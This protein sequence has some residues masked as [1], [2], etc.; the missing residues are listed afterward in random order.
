M[1]A[2]I[3]AAGKSTRTYPLTVTRPKPLLKLLD[4]TLIEHNLDQLKGIVDE[5][6]IV[7]GF[8][9]DQIISK[10][11]NLYSGIKISYIEQ[12]EQL[13]T[14]HALQI[15]KEA[16]KEEEQILVMVGDD[17]YSAEDIKKCVE[18]KNCMLACVVPNP[19]D[20]GVLEVENG[21]LIKI[22]E[23]QKDPISELVNTGLYV[24]SSEIFDK[25]ETIKKSERGE[26]ELTDAVSMLKIDV[27]DV[28]GYWIPV[29]YPWNLLEANVFMLKKCELE[30][31]GT[32]E[33]NVTIKGKVHIGKG[34]IIK[35]GSYIEGPV[36]IGED[37]EIGPMAHIRPDTI[38][39]NNVRMGKTELYDVLI[40]DGATSKHMGYCAH[41]IVG[42]NVNFG[43]GTITADYRHDGKNNFTKIK[44]QKI[45]TR[46]RKLGAFIGDNVNTGIGTL[47]YPGRKL[48]PGTTTLPGEIV[49]EDKV[50]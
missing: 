23:K 38:I 49:K 33:E 8:E 24:I 37:C 42:E 9:K 41:S 30:N 45:D 48:W 44:G 20:Y 46:R 12:T 25:L 36:Y 16:V 15:C 18:H 3:F 13:G 5:V 7:V 14:G 29:S 39:G 1:K 35:S 50:E 32:V 2:I 27:L 6:I 10:L 40:M 47:I 11:G 34:S 43:A 28:S 26:L 19:E 17:V 21:K 31:H 4:K 22:H